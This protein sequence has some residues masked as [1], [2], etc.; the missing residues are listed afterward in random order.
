VCVCVC[1]CEEDKKIQVVLEYDFW[2][3]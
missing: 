1:V 3:I 2:V